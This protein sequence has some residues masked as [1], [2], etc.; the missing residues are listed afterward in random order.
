MLIF[1]L[2]LQQELIPFRFKMESAHKIK[3]YQSFKL[4]TTNDILMG[5]NTLTSEPNRYK[6]KMCKKT[7]TYEE[8]TLTKMKITKQYI[9]L[10]E[11]N[12]VIH[13]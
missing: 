9:R 13:L 6:Q 12:P 7:S 10:N 8:V 4:Y 11:P 2:E 1:I 3:G 5:K